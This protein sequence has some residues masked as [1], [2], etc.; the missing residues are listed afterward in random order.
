M[1]KILIVAA[2]YMDLKISSNNRTNFLPQFLHNKGYDVE[3][4]TSNFNHHR[5]EHIISVEIRDYKFTVLEETGYKKNVSIKRIISIFTY[6]KNLKKYLKS[7]ESVD[8]VYTF[9]PAHSIANVAYKYAKRVNAKFVIDVRDLWPEAFRMVVKNELIHKILFYPFKKQADRTYKAADLVIAVSDTYKERALSVNKKNIKGETIYLGTSISDFD[10]YKNCCNITKPFNEIWI[11]YAG[12]LGNSYDLETLLKAYKIVLDSGY[13]NIKLH[14]LGSGPKEN[15]LKTLDSS[16]GTKVV[17]HGRLPYDQMA[18]FISKCDIGLNPLIKESYG[19]IINKHA[20]YAA[21]GLPVI[22]S[23][24]TKEYVEMVNNNK[25][26]YNI[27]PGNELEM[28]ECIIR[29]SEN[30]N[31]LILMGENHRNLAIK[32]FDRDI[33]YNKLLNLL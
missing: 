27:S 12:T 15:S 8:I 6:K 16:L 19:S 22:S 26:G 33:I 5:K 23:Q 32:V 17:F 21:A 31:E 14:I 3:L 20:D 1:K 18:S 30:K 7:K 29:M 13:N 11:V 9:V 2:N 28:A 10:S 24:I 25:L 4:V